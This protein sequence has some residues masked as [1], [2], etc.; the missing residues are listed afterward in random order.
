VPVRVRARYKRD[1]RTL[2]A[3]PATS[4]RKAHSKSDPGVTASPPA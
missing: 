1:I 2:T 3:M 4:A